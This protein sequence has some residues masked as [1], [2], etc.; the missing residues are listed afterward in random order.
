MG[1]LDSIAE[2]Y[3]NGEIFEAEEPQIKEIPKLTNKEVK[4]VVSEEPAE[5]EFVHSQKPIALIFGWGG[6]S[7]KNVAKYSSIYQKAGCTTIQYVLPTRHLFRDT[8]QIPELMDN[9]LTQME[10]YNILERPVYIHC[11]CDTGVM[12]YQGLD[13]AAGRSERNLNIQGVVW[14]SCPGPY[15]EFTAIRL[16]VFSV[17]WFLCCIRDWATGEASLT[18]CFNSTYSMITDRVIP[19]FVD[20]WNGKPVQYSLIEGIWAGHFGRDHCSHRVG[21]PELFLYSNKDYYLS[22]NYLEDTVLTLRQKL[23]APFRAIKFEGSPH[24]AH[25]RNHNKVY[26][27]EII[28]FVTKVCT[29]RQNA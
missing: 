19:S 28:S 20:N 21:M 29:G 15:P 16:L 14:D 17:V 18:D 26:T 10:E 13:I 4:I 22:H 5:S 12:C 6:S 27:D 11:L 1:A 25:L 24:V 23:G 7:H 8:D 2:F 3:L 9:V